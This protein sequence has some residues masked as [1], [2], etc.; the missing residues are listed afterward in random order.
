MGPILN[1][2]L[3]SDARRT[4]SGVFLSYAARHSGDGLGAQAQRLLGIFGAARHLGFGYLHQSIESLE[5]NPGDPY[6]TV[7]GRREHLERANRLFELPSDLTPRFTARVRLRTLT[8]WRVKALRVLDALM[9]M[10][11][12]SVVVELTLP[13]PWI[14]SNVACYEHAASIIAPRVEREAIE[15]PFRVD[16]HIRRALAPAVGSS[17]QPYDRYIPTS[18]YEQVVGLMM[19]YLNNRDI[20]VRIRIHTDLTSE[21]W[22]VPSDTSVGTRA[23]WQHHGL[24]DDD[25]YL[26]DLYE[27]L[28]STFTAF[29]PVELAQ[30]W[31]PL[32]ALN[33]MV[34]ADILVTY[35]SSLSY[36]AGLLRRQR[37]TV[38]PVFFHNCPS[39]WLVPP[40]EISPAIRTQIAEDLVVLLSESKEQ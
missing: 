27:D 23:M 19:D 6:R 9:R 24:I 2:G 21:P 36:V 1:R 7:H 32:D 29:A 35:A 33:S 30:E 26:V 4:Q 5:L 13:F 12:A 10:C 40:R 22:K 15:A 18:W 11:R 20:D 37:P 25:G 16:L 31:D 28:A 34:T 17:G 3:P 39:M 8:N 38:S 14:D